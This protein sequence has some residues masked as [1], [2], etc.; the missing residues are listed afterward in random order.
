MVTSLK[1]GLGNFKMDLFTEDQLEKLN[2]NGLSNPKNLMTIPVVSL[3]IS[4]LDFRWLLTEILPGKG[5]VGYGL[6]Y[7][8][9]KLTYG[10]IDLKLIESFYNNDRLIF[11]NPIFETNFS[12]GV[13]K[14]VAEELGTI[15]TNERIFDSYFNKYKHLNE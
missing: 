2:K 11:N 13:F 6:S 1:V 8:Y 4:D 10:E 7:V 3:S 9:K 12:I 14:A 15:V 5:N